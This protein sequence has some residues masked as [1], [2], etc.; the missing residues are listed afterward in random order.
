MKNFKDSPFGSYDDPYDSLTSQGPTAFEEAFYSPES[1]SSPQRAPQQQIPQKVQLPDNIF[2]PPNATSIDIRRVANVD[3][4]TVNAPFM[5]FRAPE[6]AVARFT[7]YAVFSD[8]TL[9]A[10]Q[11]FFPRINGNR[12]FP[13]HGDPGVDGEGAF[14]INLGLSPDLGNEALVSCNL[15]LNPNELIQWSITNTNAVAIAM[16]VRMV[17]YLEYTAQRE[18]NNFGG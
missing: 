14:E 2:L 9:A 15:T 11:R 4:A 16:G 17:G 6:G 1:A 12:I 13:Y 5:G 8:G 10:G 3:P 18:N 7:H